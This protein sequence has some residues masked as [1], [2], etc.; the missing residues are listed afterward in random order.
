MHRPVKVAHSSFIEGR[1][2][3]LGEIL[4]FWLLI[5]GEIWFVVCILSVQK[6][7]VDGVLDIKIELY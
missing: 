2:T 6:D 5:K 7:F 4:P 3:R 1:G